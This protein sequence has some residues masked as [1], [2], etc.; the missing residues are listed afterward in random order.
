M[1]TLNIPNVPLKINEVTLQQTKDPEETP[2]RPYLQEDFN[3][4]Y[5][6]R[7]KHIP[8]MTHNLKQH[9]S[10]YT[11]SSVIISIFPVSKW[12]PTYKCKSN[13]LSDLGSGFTV[14]VMHVPQGMAYGAL[15][16]V[17]PIIG[18]Y[19]AIYPV[20]VY[21]L[22]GTSRHVSMGSFAVTCLM[23]SKPIYTYSTPGS[24]SGDFVT[25]L[26]PG[27]GYS[28]PQ[29]AAVV[30]LVVGAVQ[31]ILGVSRVGSLSMFLSE[32]LVSGFT[33]GAAVLV[34]VSQ[35]EHVFGVDVPPTIGN[36]SV[37]YTVYN[38]IK[39]ISETNYLALLIAFSVIL[40]LL[41]YTDILK[42]KLNCNIIFPIDL[43]IMVLSTVLSYSLNFHTSYSI[44]IVGSIPTGLMIPHVP[45]LELIPKVF[46]DSLTI[47]IVSYSI[48]IS[49]AK[50]FA[51]KDNYKIDANQELIA[52]G[53]GNVV[54]AFFFCLPM[55]ASLSR[56]MLQYH[57]GG[58]TQLTSFFSC[59]LLLSV[60][61]YFGAF[62]DPLP[63]CVLAG[64]VIARLKSM[65]MQITH[66]PCI[67]RQ[68]SI[69]GVVWI[70][71]FVSVVILDIHIGLMVALLASILSIVCINQKVQVCLLGQIP[72][73]DLY[74]ELDRYPT[75]RKVPG[76]I[77]IQIQAG[78]H[79]ANIHIVKERMKDIFQAE[80]NDSNEDHTIIIDMSGVAF[81]DST[82]L[83]NLLQFIDTTFKKANLNTCLSHC[84][85][86]VYEKIKKC[87]FQLGCEELQIFP[88]T[89][90]AIIYTM[91][92]TGQ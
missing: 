27:A 76:F 44:N 4:A 50:L 37:G 72:N 54:G 39:S 69:D 86:S 67:W 45:P 28:P 56:S 10:K 24:T 82:A 32:T 65:L 87:K 61:L 18:I 49:M 80:I 92:K 30:C 13:L 41:G 22:M 43:I 19:T 81:I 7:R 58:K 47:A 71:T 84:S 8:P 14:A 3:R 11:V 85:T 25:A 38:L 33:S 16:G 88:A 1:F 62:L 83:Q 26:S 57:S 63:Y 36:F 78:L 89:H 15:G 79:F 52:C 73:T 17:H 9:C 29:V 48:N 20:L 12:L 6:Y 66:L 77:L 46:I 74:L 31:V 2:E 21:F 90:N 64:I 42:P 91:K 23:A 70:A 34:F 55:A 60:I 5:G 35:L 59:L 51:V 53:S 68:S 40:C 75:A